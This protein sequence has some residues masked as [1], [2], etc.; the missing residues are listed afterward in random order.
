MHA[1]GI[2]LY[3]S[4]LLEDHRH[5]LGIDLPQVIENINVLRELVEA[6]LKCFGG[7]IVSSSLHVAQSEIQVGISLCRIQ[8]Y[9]LI[10]R[11]NGFS[12]LAGADIGHAK[13]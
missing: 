9:G 5:H 4:H 3:L 2:R 8:G 11:G 13:E 7:F 1:I 12:I 6:L 10:E